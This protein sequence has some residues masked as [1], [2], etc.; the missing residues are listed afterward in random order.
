[1][2]V[3][4]YAGLAAIAAR[5]RRY[6]PRRTGSI[7][8]AVV[9]VCIVVWWWGGQGA[10]DGVRITQLAV[11]RGTS[12]VIEL[13]DG[14]VWLY[15][16]GASGNYDPGAGVI[17]PY[18]HHRGIR[19]LAGIIISHPNLDHFGG[20]PSLID[21]VASGPV[22]LSPHFAR[23]CNEDGPCA[24]LLE[25][26]EARGHPI[27]LVDA[28]ETLQ[29]GDG[30]IAEAL[31]PPSKLPLG[32]DVNDGSLVLRLCYGTSS[33]LFTGDIGY[34]P[35]QWLMDHAD[36]TADVLVLPHH[37]SVEANTRAFIQTVGA[38]MLVRSTF[39]PSAES[40]ALTAAV[41]NNDL[42]N[43]ADVGAVEIS[44]GREGIEIH[45]SRAGAAGAGE[46]KEQ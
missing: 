39:T 3:L 44:L 24:V 23:Q 21:A 11:G 36:P 6:L 22:Y 41:G 17:V 16:A 34:V 43:T 35:Q 46:P 19:R 26:L 37:G 20:V 30:V 10:P 25:W 7:A 4:Y 1:L 40:P 12:T 27:V 5:A 33:V 18:L 29:L 31:W 14:N 8:A 15:D 38:S 42:Y 9:C 2:I 28:D 32:L 45:G 13:P